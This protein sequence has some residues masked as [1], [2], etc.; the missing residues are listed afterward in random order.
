MD[1]LPEPQGV[2]PRRGQ[3][4]PRRQAV[5]AMKPMEQA[6]PRAEE[7]NWEEF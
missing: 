3:P 2:P 6:A 7:D 4:A 5:M 1:I